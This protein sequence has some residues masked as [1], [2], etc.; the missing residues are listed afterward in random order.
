MQG[1]HRGAGASWVQGVRLV[2]GETEEGHLQT[3]P[4]I[5]WEIPISNH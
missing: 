2:R 3:V 5:Y 4:K 1:V